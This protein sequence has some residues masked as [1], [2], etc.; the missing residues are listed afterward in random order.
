ME[1]AFEAWGLA[2]M[3]KLADMEAKQKII[4]SEVNRLIKEAVPKEDAMKNPDGQT[5]VVQSSVRPSPTQDATEQLEQ[6]MIVEQDQDTAGAPGQPELMIPLVPRARRIKLKRGP[7]I[8]PPPP[9]PQESLQEE[10]LR[11]MRE[12]AAG[13][14]QA[15][16]VS[17]ATGTLSDP[18][19]HMTVSTG[20]VQSNQEV[21]PADA[22]SMPV[23]MDQD[24]QDDTATVVTEATSA[25]E[26]L[27]LATLASTTRRQRV[28]QTDAPITKQSAKVSLRGATDFAFEVEARRALVLHRLSQLPNAVGASSYLTEHT[29]NTA[30]SQFVL[31][32]KRNFA[33]LYAPDQPKLE[34][35]WSQAPMELKMKLWTTS[36]Q[37]RVRWAD[38]DYSKALFRKTDPS[39]FTN[40]D[41]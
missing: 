5:I 18:T 27:P 23:A 17:S 39:H 22:A 36:G 1:E 4:F 40:N 28:E 33:A 9:L 31:P 12:A 15:Q 11:L 25:S 26:A 41:I 13:H 32:K 10:R 34:G 21:Q 14:Q 19:L 8:P 37:C 2:S 35:E 30:Q 20:Q 16:A 24:M 6:P 38:H 29:H 3:S 7:V